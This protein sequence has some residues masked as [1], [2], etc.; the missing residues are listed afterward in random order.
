MKKITLI[1]FAALMLFA[2][3]SNGNSGT[4]TPAPTETPTTT[5][6]TDEIKNLA[7]TNGDQLVVYYG[8]GSDLKITLKAVE[9]EEAIADEKAKLLESIDAISKLEKE[10]IEGKNIT[11]EACYIVKNGETSDYLRFCETGDAIYSNNE[12]RVLYRFNAETFEP[13]YKEFASQ[14]ES[15]AAKTAPKEQ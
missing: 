10:T 4:N 7:S 13:L 3:T 8:E 14:I 2:C 5:E 1:L 9:G 11:G 6:Q 15:V 12:V